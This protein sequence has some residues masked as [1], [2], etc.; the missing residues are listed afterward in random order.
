MKARAF[1]LSSLILITIAICLHLGGLNKASAG[2]RYRAPVSATEE[3]KQ[4]YNAAI[5]RIVS[6]SD[7]LI[8]SGLTFAIVSVICLVIS[9]RKKEKVSRAIIIALMSLYVL[10]QLVVV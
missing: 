3:Q 9:F 1:W 4:E 8:L 10:L 6:Q 7:V 5:K 2:L